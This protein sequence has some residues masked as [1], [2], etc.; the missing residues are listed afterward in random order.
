[1]ET[2]DLT[3]LQMNAP[4]VRDSTKGKK[5]KDVLAHL[6]P[7]EDQQGS[8]E[9]ARSVDKLAAVLGAGRRPR[10]SQDDELV[11]PRS[12]QRIQ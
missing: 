1:M 3:I 4:I 9:E 8:D 12:S 11:S 10:E 6:Q 5:K 2:D 7:V